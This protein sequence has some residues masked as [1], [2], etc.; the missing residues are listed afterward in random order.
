MVR[1]QI[2]K[3]P[4][5]KPFKAAIKSKRDIDSF[6]EYDKKMFRLIF[7]LNQLNKY[8]HVRTA[9]LA[10]EFN[11]TIRTVQ[12]DIA[13]LNL[14]GFPLE[15]GEAGEHKFAEGFSLRKITVSPE[16]KYLLTILIV[17][18][19]GQK[20]HCRPLRMRFLAKS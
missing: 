10:K 3:I 19:Q 14:A 8:R 18:L 11:T 4:N 1:K 9:E 6:K 2:V 13:L 15:P 16:E 12:R 7:I 17:F 20:G 5:K